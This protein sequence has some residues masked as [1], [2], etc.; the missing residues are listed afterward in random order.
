MPSL[1]CRHL[2]S[3]GPG[4]QPQSRTALVPAAIQT[5][6]STIAAVEGALDPTTLSSLWDQGS[7]MTLTQATVYALEHL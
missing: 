2:A 5:R 7:A 4:S 3:C 1:T 6:E